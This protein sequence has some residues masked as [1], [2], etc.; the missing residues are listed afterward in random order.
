MALDNLIL[1]DDSHLEYH[2][3]VVYICAFHQLLYQFV[4]NIFQLYNHEAVIKRSISH[5]IKPMFLMTKNT[6][7]I[8]MFPS[9][10]T[11]VWIKIPF[12]CLKVNWC[13]NYIILYKCTNYIV[14]ST[15]TL[16]TCQN[17]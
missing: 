10:L 1:E 16:I 11:N 3:V 14:Y 9:F 7:F 12:G 2:F 5:L 13:S 4:L 8:K 6:H 17:H 15:F